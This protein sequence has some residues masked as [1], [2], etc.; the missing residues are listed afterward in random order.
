MQAADADLDTSAGVCRLASRCSDGRRRRPRSRACPSARRGVVC[1]FTNTRTARSIEATKASRDGERTY[2]ASASKPEPGGTF[3]SRRR[4]RTRRRRTSSRSR[5]QGRRRDGKIAWTTSRDIDDGR[6]VHYTEQFACSSQGRTNVVDL[7]GDNPSTPQ[8]ETDYKLDTD[9][10]SVTVR[11]SETPPPPPPPPP[12]VRTDEFMDVQV[13]KDATPQVQ[14]VNGQADIAYTVRVRNNGPN[15]A[16][17]VEAGRRG[18]ERGHVH[19]GSR[20]SR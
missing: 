16:H 18:S 3:T 13:V 12:T 4:S 6:L 19:S 5:A 1:T 11:C 7:L 10:A 8:V 9:S 2:D 15:Q 17:D 20:S 14:L